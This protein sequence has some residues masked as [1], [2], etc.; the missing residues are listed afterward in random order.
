MSYFDLLIAE[1]RQLARN[2][3]KL[4][5][6][7]I[8][9]VACVFGLWKGFAF[10]EARQAEIETIESQQQV[11]VQQAAGWLAEGVNGPE[12][13]P[14][15]NVTEPFWAM[16]YANHHAFD[17]PSPMTVFSIGQ[18]DQF[19]FYKRVSMWTTGYDPDLVA[20]L[21]NPEFVGIGSLDFTFIWIFLLPVLLIILIYDVK[22]LEYDLGF[23][24][25]ITLHTPNPYRWLLQRLS[26]Y[27]LFMLGLLLLAVLVPFLMTDMALAPMA[28]YLAYGV[29]YLFIWFAI[30]FLI[31]TK[32]KGQTDQA[33]KMLI[34]WLLVAVVVPGG[35][36]QYLSLKHPPNYM[37]DW[38]TTK[39]VEQD[40]IFALPHA[41]TVARVAERYDWLPPEAYLHEDSVSQDVK[42]S[43]SRLVLCMEFE[44]VIDG[45]LNTLEQKNQAIRKAHVVSPVMFFQN[46]LNHLCGTDYY[47]NRKFRQAIQATSL[48]I[49]EQILQGELNQVKID[50]ARFKEYQLIGR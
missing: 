5:A 41:E 32:G 22:G 31:I 4:L 1:N 39:R 23:L 12:N 10:Y 26:Y 47:A 21:Q 16:W 20:D 27:F 29:L 46:R 30:Y 43:L 25:S 28:T 36:H 33:V 24:K 48:K 38:L 42:N 18:A 15:V 2:P 45:I 17:A 11:L 8:F 6:L 50:A 34:V 40:E 7:F 35:V 3:Y 9:V 37:M 49:N 44:A 19:A 14:W 13:R